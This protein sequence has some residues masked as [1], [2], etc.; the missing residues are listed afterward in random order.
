[1]QPVLHTL[2]IKRFLH[3]EQGA[4]ALEYALLAAFVAI[5]VALAVR[6]VGSDAKSLYDSVSSCVRAAAASGDCGKL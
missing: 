6:L 1:M 2:R 3:D 5:V 4:S